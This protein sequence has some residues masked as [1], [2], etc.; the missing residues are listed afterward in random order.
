MSRK[1]EYK[2]LYT[3][4]MHGRFYNMLANYPHIDLSKYDIVTSEK[5]QTDFGTKKAAPL[6]VF[7]Q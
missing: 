1:Q 7:Q 6:K 3:G 5:T 2:N 4:T